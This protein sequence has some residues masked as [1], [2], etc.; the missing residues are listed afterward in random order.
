MT[1]TEKEEF[2]K[3]VDGWIGAVINSDFD[4]D[5][6]VYRAPETGEI[7][8]EPSDDF[9][10]GQR[11]GSSDQF[12]VEL[13]GRSYRDLTLDA[14]VEEAYGRIF[15]GECAAHPETGR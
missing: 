1:D 9:E 6:T 14:Q 11:I 8:A 5:Y 15:S 7:F 2:M 4:G 10:T 3:S 13:D 12:I